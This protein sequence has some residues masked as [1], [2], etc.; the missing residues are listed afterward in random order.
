MESFGV[1]LIWNIKIDLISTYNYDITIRLGT[2]KWIQK[3][4]WIQDEI[5]FLF[6]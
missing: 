6:L 5:S 3:K 4:K 2:K 1:F